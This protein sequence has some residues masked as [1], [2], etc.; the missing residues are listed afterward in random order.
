MD[1]ALFERAKALFIEGLE[2]FE[3]GRH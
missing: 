3:A 1:E 2:H